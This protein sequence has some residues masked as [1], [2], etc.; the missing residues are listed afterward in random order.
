[1]INR[2][3]FLLGV[4]GNVL[5]IADYL[6]SSQ[7][8]DGSIAKSGYV[9]GYPYSCLVKISNTGVVSRFELSVTAKRDTGI[10]DLLRAVGTTM[11][12]TYYNGQ[13]LLVKVGDVRANFHVLIDG[14]LFLWD[15][16]IAKRVNPGQ[17]AKVQLATNTMGTLEAQ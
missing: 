13:P 8:S 10:Y 5:P 16:I 12:L 2:R 11:D 17:V 4:F 9:N 1:M 7:L 14:Q 3:M 15:N 6:V